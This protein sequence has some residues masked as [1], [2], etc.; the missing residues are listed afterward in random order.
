[1]HTYADI[2]ELANRT[3]LLFHIGKAGS[4]EKPDDSDE[5][6]IIRDDGEVFRFWH[7][8]DCCEN[9]EI[10]DVCGDPDDMLESPLSLA[11]VA[12]SLEGPDKARDDSNTWTFYKF[13]TRKGFLDIRWMGSSNGY[14]SERVSFSAVRRDEPEYK[15]AHL[16]LAEKTAVILSSEALSSARKSA[17]RKI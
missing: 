16:L 5:I 4:I 9:V 10:V 7:E 15:K 14:Y 12:S 3:L 2:P 17:P 8:Q 11:E 13:A 1:M 6:L